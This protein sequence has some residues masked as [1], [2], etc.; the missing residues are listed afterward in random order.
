MLALQKKK[1]K[2]NEK[3]K[4]YINQGG[5]N[6]NCDILVYYFLVFLIDT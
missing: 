3:Q 6:S 5:R 2:T 4:A 1:K